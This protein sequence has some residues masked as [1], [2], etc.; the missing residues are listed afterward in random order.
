MGYHVLLER[1]LFA[2]SKDYP[3]RPLFCC[4]RDE[5]LIL[6]VCILA[7]SFFIFAFRDKIIWCHTIL[8]FVSFTKISHSK[9]RNTK[10]FKKWMHF[11][12]KNILLS[13]MNTLCYIKLLPPLVAQIL[14]AV[15]A[16]EDVQYYPCWLC[17]HGQLYLEAAVSLYV[18]LINWTPPESLM[19]VQVCCC[20]SP[21]G[22][23]SFPKIPTRGSSNK[24]SKQPQVSSHQ[25]SKH[26][27]FYP[28]FSRPN[29]CHRIESLCQLDSSNPSRS[30][31][32]YCKFNFPCLKSP[33]S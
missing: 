15:L 10:Q 3:E 17:L 8:L 32:Q 2:T 13:K 1:S 31:V 25:D 7:S 24:L 29:H 5:R 21:L 18:V 28:S 33:S 4:H 26:V 16:L 27:S 19:F 14:Q 11:Q 12:T 9:R 23:K 6:L 30:H 22:S 20:E